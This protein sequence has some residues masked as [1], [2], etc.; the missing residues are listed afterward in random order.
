MTYDAQ[1]AETAIDGFVLQVERVVEAQGGRCELV[2]ASLAGLSRVLAN[3]PHQRR[4]VGRI[5]VDRLE[6]WLAER[7]LAIVPSPDVRADPRP[8]PI[9]LMDA[10]AL[11]ADCR[12]WMLP[13]GVPSRMPSELENGLQKFAEAG[14][15]AVQAFDMPDLQPIAMGLLRI[16][17]LSTL[18]EHAGCEEE[19]NILSRWSGSLAR[20]VLRR[21]VM[22]VDA[23]IE[24]PP[25]P[26]PRIDFA[27]VATRFDD[28]VVVIGRVFEASRLAERDTYLQ[29]VGSELLERFSSQL[30]QLTRLLLR[31]ATTLSAPGYTELSYGAVLMQL[32][33]LHGLFLLLQDRKLTASGTIAANTIA[34][35]CRNA[36]AADRAA[37]G[38]GGDAAWPGKRAMLM[39]M[40]RSLRV[41]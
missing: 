39:E 33:R 16:E 32:S 2:S 29:S 27:G 1:T 10:A 23:Y 41:P 22:L 24:N 20:E 17:V 25:A 4:R 34:E 12:P 36:V 26:V 40:Q 38:G 8:I 35:W 18:L 15:T 6:P 14:R 5:I 21:V 7:L 3:N 19:L 30:E 11:Y 13:L 37:P 9:G 28:L 31:A